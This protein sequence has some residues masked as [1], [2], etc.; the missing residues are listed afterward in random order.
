MTIAE[1]DDAQLANL[2]HRRELARSQ[3]CHD[4]AMIITAEIDLLL[5]ERHEADS[6][7]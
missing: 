6:G 1:I 5:K 4:L 3:H 7:T 2:T